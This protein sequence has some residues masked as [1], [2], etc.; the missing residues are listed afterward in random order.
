LIAEIEREDKL[1]NILDLTHWKIV[2]QVMQDLN[3]PATEESTS[4]GTPAFKVKKKLLLRLKEDGETMMIHADD[5][6]I[7]LE[8]DPDVFFFT[9][10]YRN[11]P[12][13]LVRLKKIGRKKLRVL[14]MQC[15]KEIAPP[16][17]VDQWN[18]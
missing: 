12:A 14:I 10:H 11:Y 6:D 1:M 16:K 4:Y 13:V 15:W 7:W 8:D 9:E 3:F 5:R 2:R 18:K 17:L